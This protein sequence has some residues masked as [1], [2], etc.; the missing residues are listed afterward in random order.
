MTMSRPTVA[1]IPAS[2]TMIRVRFRRC[3]SNPCP[4]AGS[5][6]AGGG[7]PPRPASWTSLSIVSASVRQ[8][9]AP[10]ALRPPRRSVRGRSRCRPFGVSPRTRPTGRPGGGLSG[11]GRG[12][13]QLGI[14]PRRWPCS[15]ERVGLARRWFHPVHRA[16]RSASTRWRAVAIGGRQGRLRG[17]RRRPGCGARRPVFPC[18]CRPCCRGGWVVVLDPS[19]RRRCARLI[20]CSVSA[21]LVRGATAVGRPG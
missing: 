3:G 13:R 16:R 9:P 11:A 14:W 10:R 19:R 12:Q 7:P 8:V 21:W 17:G 1:A 4:G 6:T 2:S 18:W 15:P 20:P 5:S